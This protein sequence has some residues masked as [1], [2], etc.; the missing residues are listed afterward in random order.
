MPGS[1]LG[2]AVKRREDPRLVTG[3]GRYVDDVPVDRCLHAAFVRSP[4]AHATLGPVDATAAGAAPGV[5]AVLTA[6]DLA[7]RPRLAF[8]VLPEELARP[9]LAEG[10]V[11][12][13]GD[14][15]ALVVAETR[16][17]AVDAA[18]LV[19]VEYD[20]LPVLAGVEASATEGAPLL[21]PDHGSNLAFEAGSPAAEDILAEAEVV[22]R[23]RMLNQRLAAVPMEG[24]A[25]LAIPEDD[26]LTVYCSTQSPF[27][28]RDAIADALGMDEDAVR[29]IAPDVG[30]GFGA[31]IAVYPE[32]VVVAAAARRLGR[33]V[34]HVETRSE[35][36]V[37]MNQGRAQLQDVELGARRDG[38]LVGLRVRV[39]ADAGAYPEQGAILPMFTMQ[40]A[41]GAYRIPAV[42]FVA[43]SY[44]TNTTPVAAYRGAGRPEAAALVERA[45]DLLAAE[46]GV[47][48]VEL[49]RRN[50]VAPDEFPHT[51]ATG[52]TYDT[53]DYGRALDEALRMSG[54]EE[55]RAEQRQRRAAGDPRRLGIGVACYVEVT[56]VG[57]PTE[58]AE[59]ELVEGGRI[60]VKVG[61]ANHGQGHETAFAM[62]AAE[63]LGVPYDAIDVVEGDTGRVARG[64]GTSA[65][66]S[67]QLGGSAVVE[68]SA[69]LV[70]R[71]QEVA[72]RLLEA[73]AGDVERRAGGFGVVGVPGRTVSWAEIAAAEP[74]LSA[75]SDFFLTDS[76]YP[77][78]AHVCVVEVDSDTGGV[79]VLRHVAVD[80]C[81]TVINPLLAE[82][83]V[84]GGIAQGIAQ[85]IYEEVIHDADGNPRTATLLDYTV[86]TANELP[87]FETA[88]TVTPTS[89]NPLGAKGIGESGTIGSTP[90]AWNAVLDALADAGVRHLDMPLTPERVWRALEAAARG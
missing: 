67:L 11:R 46:L 3:R 61:T 28:V 57:S 27:Q 33:P 24:T 7:L 74:N 73:D 16:A 82:G 21:F 10:R 36:L 85:A 72:A 89:N 60:V 76:T 5:V 12:F 39:L 70:E 88:H 56:A 2:S 71:A 43:R 80:D 49:R 15:V 38:T 44:V 40:M 54:Y 59:A 65:S 14:A 6:A 51:T 35:N 68:A 13:V 75:E 63:H 83:Q 69:L 1:I 20:P 37:A 79:R 9:P 50:L 41:S 18:A 77:F 87:A 32:H 62:V 26:R 34:K 19:E 31:K 48:P 22:V 52:A 8:A 81:G 25:V 42:D 90:A 86:P 53:G 64:D 45:M 30:G 58:F 29:C 84:H 4:F 47:D 78:G 55:L 23:Q 66:R 17:Q